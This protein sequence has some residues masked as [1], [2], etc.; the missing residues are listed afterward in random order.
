MPKP[1]ASPCIIYMMDVSGSMTDE[2][3][4]IVRIE[5]FWIDTWI[6]AHYQGVETVYIIHDA[7]AQEVD[8]HT[9]YHTR[10]SGGTKISSAYELANKIIDAALPADRVERLRLPLLRRRQLGR[11]HPEVHRAPDREAAA[12]AEPVRLRAGGRPYGSGEFF[13]YVHELLGRARERRREPHPG[14]R[15]DPGVDQGVP[16]DG[17]V[18]AVA[19]RDRHREERRLPM[20]RKRPATSSDPSP[21]PATRPKR[22]WTRHRPGR[23]R[24]PTLDRSFLD[25]PL[26][27]GE[28]GRLGDYRVLR[29]LGPGGMGI[30]FEAEDTHLQPAGRAE[31]DAAR[32]WPPTRRT[33]SGSSARPGPPPRSTSDHVVT[34]LPGRRG[35][36]RP[37]PGDA[38]PARRDRWR[39]GSNG[40]TRSASRT[41]LL[42]AR[43]A[44]A[45]LA[46]AHAARAGPP[47]HQAGEHLARSRRPGRAVQAGQDPR[48]R[49][50]PADAAAT[51]G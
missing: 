11:R 20:P 8:E 14:P 37:V 23:R 42:I 12:E 15:G 25:P 50:G 36:R 24:I 5:A 1:E 6:K 40:R 29:V 22:P 44:A 35:R 9:F 7:V 49:P 47:R 17:A 26:D 16:E 28:L 39:T 41:A 38:V 2:Q 32:N 18:D 30:V 45:G 46:A 31:G 33:A 43:Q 4:E 3:K 34:D 27:A 21:A 13:E 19:V 10:E 48:L 51:P